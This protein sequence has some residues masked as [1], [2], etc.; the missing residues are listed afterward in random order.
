MAIL[1]VSWSEK[2][3]LYIPVPSPFPELEAFIYEAAKA[4]NL[5]LFRCEPPSDVSKQVESVTEPSSPAA[6]LSADMP[7]NK[8]VGFGRTESALSRALLAL[9][10]I[11][12]FVLAGMKLDPTNAIPEFV[13]ILK[14]GKIEWDSGTNPKEACSG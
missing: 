10:F 6:T 7:F 3:P 1:L 13:D 5:D 9:P 11:G 12:L 8:N 14:A 2:L 4:Y